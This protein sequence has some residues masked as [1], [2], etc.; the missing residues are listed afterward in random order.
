MKLVLFQNAA[1][2]EISEQRLARDFDATHEIYYPE[3]TAEHGALES[4]SMVNRTTS[5]VR[6]ELWARYA[7]GGQDQLLH[8]GE[9]PPG[10]WKSL[11]I[12]DTD[13][14]L[15]TPGVPF[16]LILKSDGP[17][18]ATLRHDEAA[19]LAPSHPVLTALALTPA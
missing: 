15:V 14:P 9:V 18:A 1:P 2:F 16:A 12:A 10:A 8:A 4:V 5:P 19:V 7:A 17:L 11:A 3:L 6:F 13:G